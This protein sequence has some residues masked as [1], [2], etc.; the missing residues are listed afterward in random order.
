MTKSIRQKFSSEFKRE[1]VQLLELGEKN[2]SQLARELGVRRNQLYKWKNELDEHG[3]KAFP[4]KGRRSKKQ[5][6][7]K[8]IFPTSRE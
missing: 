4:G 3:E 5:D 1:A 6:I 7:E 2:A 8:H